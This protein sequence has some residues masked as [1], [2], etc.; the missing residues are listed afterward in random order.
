V[1]DFARACGTLA[2]TD[3]IDAAVLTNFGQ[4]MEP[5]PSLPP[6]PVDLELAALSANGVTNGVSP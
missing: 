3:K 2:K 6:N 4:R 5:S 1:R